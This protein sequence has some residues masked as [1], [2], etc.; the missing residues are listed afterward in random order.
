VKKSFRPGRAGASNLRAL[1]FDSPPGRCFY[2]EG[3]QAR[4]RSNPISLY[5]NAY[6]VELQARP[7]FSFRQPR[8]LVSV[9][10]LCPS[11]PPL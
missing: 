1:Y 6:E 5:F 2:L 8:Q 7:S 11:A 4:P 10:G 9:G 3:S